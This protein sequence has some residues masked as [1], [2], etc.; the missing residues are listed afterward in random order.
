LW[1]GKAGLQQETAV[2]AA[3]QDGVQAQ[4]ATTSC[5]FNFT[6][7][8]NNTY[9]VYCV[10]QNGNVFYVTTPA[11]HTHNSL[12]EGY[13]LCDANVPAVYYDYGFSGDS[14]NWNAPSVVSANATTVK[15]SRTTSDGLSTLTQ[16]ITQMASNSSVKIVMTLRNNTASTREA[17]I[18][19][20][21]Y[22]SPDGDIFANYDGTQN[23][24]FAWNSSPNPANLV[25]S[26]GLVL[27]NVGNSPF[28]QWGGFAQ[29]TALGPN[30]CAFA[31][32][33]TGRAGATQ[34]N[35]KAHEQRGFCTS[36]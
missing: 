20:Y 10:S 32:N 6:S 7:G 5:S 12:Y 28:P 9:L 4:P 8:S 33:W 29:N 2:A 14:G 1:I 25:P 26:Y 16:T 24:A 17:Y 27:Q 18:L 19:R 36:G 3:R 31:F 22:L 30:P 21:N 11:G 34:Y 13:G 15:I 23:T 35:G